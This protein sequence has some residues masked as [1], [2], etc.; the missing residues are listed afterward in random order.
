M[1]AR[2]RTAGN[3]AQLSVA[4][5]GCHGFNAFP[6]SAAREANDVQVAFL[7]QAMGV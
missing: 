4:T 1:E 5:E 7:R 3:A 6:I 2:W